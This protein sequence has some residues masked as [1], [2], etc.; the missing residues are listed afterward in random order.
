M[1]MQTLF[2]LIPVTFIADGLFLGREDRFLVIA[3]L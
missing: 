1:K 2:R 3:G